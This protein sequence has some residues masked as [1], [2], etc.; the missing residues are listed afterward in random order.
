MSAEHQIKRY[1]KKSEEKKADYV[2]S[3]EK[4][5]ANLLAIEMQDNFKWQIRP[6]LTGN[7]KEKIFQTN[8]TTSGNTWY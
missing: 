3:I 4:W 1:I 7:K 8:S 5:T 6:N 2:Q